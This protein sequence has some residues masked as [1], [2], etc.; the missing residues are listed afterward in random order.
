MPSSKPIS[1]SPRV[2]RGTTTEATPIVPPANHGRRSRGERLAT[3]DQRAD[4]RRVAE[5]LVPGD[6]DEV[7]VPAG[8]VERVR[9][10]EGRRR[11]AAR[12]SRAPG[13][14]VDPVERMADAR[15]V[16]LGGEG[17]QVRPARGGASSRAARTSAPSG[18]RSGVRS[19]RY[20][21]LASRDRANS[22]MPLTELWL[23]AVRRNRLPALNGNASPTS[24]SAPLALAVNTTVYSSGEAL[25][26]DSTARAR[27]SAN[28]VEAREAG[29]FECG[30][31]RTP[32]AS[33]SWCSRS[34]DSA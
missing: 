1:P 24:L 12:A 33:S 4:A 32:R 13:P 22:R 5:D 9:R 23:S 16:G 31:P 26:N 18:R 8:Q 27:R 20:V 7:R 28:R 21:T 19:G 17:E 15:V 3:H 6:G 29:L 11:R 30:L 34:C 10:Q 2:W 25:T 14:R